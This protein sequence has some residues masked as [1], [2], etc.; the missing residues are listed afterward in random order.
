M[1]IGKGLVTEMMLEG[2]EEVIVGR[3][4]VRRVRWVRQRMPVLLLEL[5]LRESGDVGARVVVCRTLDWAWYKRRRMRR[6]R[7]RRS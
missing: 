5:G 6:M 7:K 3:G 4:N 1:H 2:S